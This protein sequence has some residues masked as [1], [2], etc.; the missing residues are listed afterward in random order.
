MDVYPTDLLASSVTDL[1]PSSAHATNLGEHA[2][3]PG[4]R[5]K[6]SRAR[7]VLT[8]ERTVSSRAYVCW[9]MF[10]QIFISTSS[11]TR[12]RPRGFHG[13]GGA[14]PRVWVLSPARV[15]VLMGFRSDWIRGCVQPM[16]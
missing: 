6:V 2:T 15:I 4:P 9:K 11:S 14:R 7:A 3:N 12:L 10:D 13:A 8:I 1:P 5:G 16:E